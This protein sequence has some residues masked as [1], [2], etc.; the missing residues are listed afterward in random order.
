MTVNFLRALNTS[1]SILSQF[2]SAGSALTQ[3][4]TGHE[5]GLCWH[6]PL[7]LLSGS[8]PDH[9]WYLKKKTAATTT[10]PSPCKP[11]PPGACSALT[12]TWEFPEAPETLIGDTVGDL[13]K[14]GVEGA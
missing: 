3:K 13:K 1:L 2:P 5:Q 14:K 4:R 8:P 9:R 11:E 12:G 7:A 6:C 10:K